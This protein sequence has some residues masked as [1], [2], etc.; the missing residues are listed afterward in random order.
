MLVSGWAYPLDKDREVYSDFLK[1]NRPT[2]QNM[3]GWYRFLTGFTLEECNSIIDLAK[4]YLR[5]E[6]K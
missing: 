6:K 2:R 3:L 1:W 5:K 4:K